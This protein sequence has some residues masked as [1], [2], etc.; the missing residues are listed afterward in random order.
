[1]A[2]IEANEFLL[3][4]ELLDFAE[5]TRSQSLN[6]YLSLKEEI[7]LI[8]RIP[9][10]DCLIMAD[11]QSLIRIIG[12]LIKNAVHYGKDRKVLG[13]ELTETT[14]DFQLLIWDQ[15][16]GISN[17]DIGNVFERM[18]RSDYS[19]NNS[20]G[21]SGLGL[22]IAKELVEKT[23]DEFGLKAFRG[24]NDFWFSI[25]KHSNKGYLRNN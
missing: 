9:E 24:K 7:E 22:S 3:K 1:M 11:H 4:E 12:N 23:T 19:R 13:I 18:Y 25:P 5:V 20:F 6:F 14:N 8:V 15:G 16:S 10:E 17:V 2:K 21:G